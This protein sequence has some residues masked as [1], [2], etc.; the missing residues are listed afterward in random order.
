ME[1]P[2]L[3]PLARRKKLDPARERRGAEVEEEEE[4]EKE[5][6]QHRPRLMLMVWVLAFENLMKVQVVCRGV[7]VG[8]SG[9]KIK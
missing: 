1:Q 8:K 4:E 6:Q 9:V 5:Q 3:E 7:E 2:C